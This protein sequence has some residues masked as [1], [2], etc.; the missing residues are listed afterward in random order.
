[1]SVVFFFFLSSQSYLEINSLGK[2]DMSNNALLD[3]AVK[4][5]L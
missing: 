3:L 5:K 1:M 2:N 4:G